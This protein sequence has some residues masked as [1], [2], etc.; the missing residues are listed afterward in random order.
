MSP[1]GSQRP[2]PS[3]ELDAGPVRFV[4]GLRPKRSGTYR[5]EA[6]TQGTKQVIHNYGHGGAGITMSWGCAEGVREL[7]LATGLHP[8]ETP[9]AVLGAGVMGL[10]SATLLCEAGFSP[11]LYASVAPLASTSS[12]AGGPWSPSLVDYDPSPSG[13]DAFERILRHSLR[14]YEKLQGHGFGVQRRDLYTTIPSL[15]L[16]KLPHDIIPEQEPLAQLPFGRVKTPGFRYDTLM[17]E[18][19]VLLARLEQDLRATGVSFISRRFR[20]ADEVEALAEPLVI[21][22]TGL[23]SRE[24]WPDTHLHPLKGQLA[25]L[26]PQPSLEYLFSDQRGYVFPRSDGVVVG[27]T[28]T[29]E[30]D[31]SP[32]PAVGLRLIQQMKRWF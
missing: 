6:I 27:G 28:Y 18:P 19:L 12:I 2:F 25:I 15:S 21:N 7:A 16:S 24:I 31:P 14:S 3:P 4:A 23:G 13:R 29:L 20:S 5:L 10:T 11:T 22:C 8:R 32:D 30:E 1:S 26:P 9:V 17:I